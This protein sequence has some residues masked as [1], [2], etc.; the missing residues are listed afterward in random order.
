VVVV[1][2][3]PVVLLQAKQV[4]LGGHVGGV[5]DV[6]PVRHQALGSGLLYYLVEQALEALGSQTLPKAAEHG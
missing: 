4:H 5:D 6:E 3:V 2:A 1:I